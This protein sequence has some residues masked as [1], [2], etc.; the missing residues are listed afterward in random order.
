MQT[1]GAAGSASSRSTSAVR[2]TIPGRTQG[3]R[4]LDSSSA[5]DGPTEGHTSGGELWVTGPLTLILTPQM[6]NPETLP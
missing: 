5:K 2:A 3:G 4:S 6:R 1:T